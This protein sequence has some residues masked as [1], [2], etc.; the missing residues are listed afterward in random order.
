MYIYR[1]YKIFIDIKTCSILVYEN[2][3]DFS[4]DIFHTC[5]DVFHKPIIVFRA[6]R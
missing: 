4:E 5:H 6:E 1:Y 2:D 3:T